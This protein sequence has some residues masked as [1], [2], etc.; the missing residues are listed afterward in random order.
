MRGNDTATSAVGV[1]TG[2]RKTSPFSTKYAKFEGRF[3]ILGFGSIGQGTLPLVLRHLD[4]ASS[5]QVTIIVP[6]DCP[7]SLIAEKMAAE[8]R[9]NVVFA[10]LVPDN[11]VS[12]LTPLLDKG[13]FLLNVSVDVSSGDLIRFC[14]PRGVFYLD[15]CTE[16]WAGGYSDNAISL[17]DRSNYML[18][19]G[20][21]ELKRQ[22]GPTTTT[23]ISC[24][25]ANPGLVSL[26][27]KQAL[28]NIA[29]DTGV[30]LAERPRT[31]AE[32]A[33]LAQTLGIKAIHIA[34]R[35]TQYCL[36]RKKKG[37][38]VNT[39]SVDGFISEGVFQPAELGWGSHEKQ[40]P[41]GGHT[42]DKGCGA[43]IYLDK[44]GSLVQV[45][46]WTPLE[47]AFHGFLVTHNEAISIA[48]TLTVRGDDG[49]LAYRPTVHYA[50]MPCDDAVLSLREMAGN[51]FAEPKEKHLI[52]D[53][54][55]GG[56]DE[57]GVLLLGHAKGA[58]WY[59][60]QLDVLKARELAP[61][62]SATT[63]QVTSTIIGGVV[64]ALQNPTAGMVEAD[65]IMDFETLLDI[66][67]P[68]CEPVV[69]VYSDWTPLKD[70]H[71]DL[72]PEDVDTEDPF[73][74]K[75]IIV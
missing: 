10:R 13:D 48:D 64:W 52:T 70:R 68:Y 22:L 54:V 58:Y 44:P 65:E 74:F 12:L 56:K 51:N 18:R 23:A 72:F 6:R 73:Q 25:G 57:L 55:V 67:K 41:K 17:A 47:G 1:D 3:V 31:R 2:C 9:V 27:V 16:P 26:F 40:L 11:Y 28:L 61:H 21:L 38:F 36:Q 34:E 75:N 59:G 32:W 20:A 35:D 60:S 49:A 43:A 30:K 29:S 42:H 15:T 8:Y 71:V 37:E 7:T 24:L 50:Y 53:E 46:T 5:K 63:L 66:A 19:E 69:G 62:N 39:W 4:M 33:S 45:R 14:S